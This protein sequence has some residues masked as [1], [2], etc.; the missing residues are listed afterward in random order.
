MTQPPADYQ[1]FTRYL[2][3]KRTVDD[4][5]LNRH[6]W[7]T[8]RRRVHERLQQAVAPFQ[9]LEIGAGIGTMIERTV[10]WGL[11]AA[12]RQGVHY[13]A[14]DSAPENIAVAHTR[15]RS[16]APW[17]HPELLQADVRDLV[18]DPAQTGRCDLLIANAFLDLVDAPS[19]LPRLAQ[20]LRPGGLAY[21]TINFDGATILEPEL[22]PALDRAIEDAYHRTMDT[23]RVDDRPSGDSRTGRH[24]FTHLPR[25]GFHLLD[26]GSSDWV[27]FGVDGRY[28]GDEATF[29]HWIIA[30]MHGALKAAPE[31]PAARFD[32]WIAARHAQIDR[33]EL[34]YIAHQVDFLAETRAP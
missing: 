7:D 29:L 6:V 20:L 32:S 1:S 12:Q 19:L 2:A 22:E 14:V 33:G 25:S 24:L 17:L 5:A 30:T 21:F 28:P 15:L 8:L 23:R 27:V 34:V 18:R 26:A 9:V 4:R 16:V 11:F 3:A 10:E 31:L 13:T